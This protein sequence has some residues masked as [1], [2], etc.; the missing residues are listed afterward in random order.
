M[1]AYEIAMEQIAKVLKNNEKSKQ[2]KWPEP[3][4]KEAEERRR[5]FLWSQVEQLS[6]SSG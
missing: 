6:N 3:M 1:T 4:T 2:V 5:E